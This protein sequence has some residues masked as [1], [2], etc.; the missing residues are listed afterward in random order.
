MK[1]LLY[2]IKTIFKSNIKININIGIFIF[3]NRT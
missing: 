2:I 3:K 1:L